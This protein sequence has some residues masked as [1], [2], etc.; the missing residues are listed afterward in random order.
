M[1]DGLLLDA[2]EEKRLLGLSD[3]E[4]IGS[5]I[6]NHVCFVRPYA[7]NRWSGSHQAAV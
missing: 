6:L 3:D 5:L 2:N 7:S 4:N 1:R